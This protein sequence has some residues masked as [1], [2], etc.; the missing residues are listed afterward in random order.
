MEIPGTEAKTEE[1]LLEGRRGGLRGRLK[2]TV[3]AAAGRFPPRLLSLLVF[4]AGLFLLVHALAYL[5]TTL[6]PDGNTRFL[7]A[8][9][10][11]LR[12]LEQGAGRIEALALG[13][14]HTGALDMAALG[15][16]NGYRF[17]RAD[18]DLFETRHYLE[19]LLPRLPRAGVVLIPLSYFSFETDNS[20]AAEVELRRAHL[21]AS[22][23]SWRFLEGDFLN[24]LRGKSQV[25]FPVLSLV[26][27]DNWEGVF[28]ALLGDPVE[29]KG[30]IE[31]EA[32]D[33]S[34][35]SP[36]QMQASV[37]NRVAK[38][39]RLTGEMRARNPALAQENAANVAAIQQLGQALGRRVVFF[40]PPYLQS[41]TEHY[42]EQD[43]ETLAAMRL[44]VERLVREQGI[45]YYDFSQSPPFTRSPELY[46]DSDHL[47]ACG[48]QQFSQLFREALAK[49]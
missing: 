31:V 45:E 2:E 49:R 40:T 8:D 16:Q 36:E 12:R 30:F 6:A 15:Y 28:Y 11:H 10:E 4:T 35:L 21:Y 25:Y 39:L 38:Y 20:L 1:Y 44:A 34:S 29:Q 9:L 43:G 32:G 41:Y 19:Q 24:L 13:N 22:V 7:Q 33:C 14:S 48:M 46:K 18:G 26:R 27:E 37:E 42:Q 5:A 3:P 47:N 17:A 23:D